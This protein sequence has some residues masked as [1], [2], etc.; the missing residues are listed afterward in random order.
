V[1]TGVFKWLWKVI[2]AAAAGVAALFKKIFSRN[3]Q[4]A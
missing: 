2:A 3:K 4:E 1:K